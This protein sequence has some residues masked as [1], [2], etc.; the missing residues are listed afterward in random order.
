MKEYYTII[1]K[2]YRLPESCNVDLGK[3]ND[4]F[5]FYTEKQASKCIELCFNNGEWFNDMKYGK[6]RYYIEK[7][8][9]E[10]TWKE[11]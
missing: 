10:Y 1:M 3:E 6:V 4:S 8:Q 11:A 7:I 2:Y 5:L 9:Y